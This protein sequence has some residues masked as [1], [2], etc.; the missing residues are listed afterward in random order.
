M[1]GSCLLGKAAHVLDDGCKVRRAPQNDGSERS[2][3]GLDDARDAS[4]IRVLR[5]SVECKLM[6]NLF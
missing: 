2:V 4:T 6:R 5:V 1:V 3:V